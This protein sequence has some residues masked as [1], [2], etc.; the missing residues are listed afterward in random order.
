VH[1]RWSRLLERLDRVALEPAAAIQLRTGALY[2]LGLLECQRDDD[3]AIARLEQLEA[4]GGFDAEAIVNQL[5]FLYHGFRGEI[6]LALRAREK[7]ERYALHQGTAWQVEIWSTSTMSAMYGQT[8]DGAGHKNVLEQLE[9]LKNEIP[10]LTLYWQRAC[11]TQFLVRGDPLRAI[12]AYEQSLLGL[13]PRELIGWAFVRG[14]MAVAHN[15]LG[16]Y[17]EAKRICDETKAVF[18]DD[19]EYV[20]LNLTVY[21]ESAVA[22]AG[23]GNFAAASRS[24]R[25]L[26]DRHAPRKNPM[27][28]G[29]L[30]RARA[31]VARLENDATAFDQHVGM[32]EYWFRSTKNPALIAQCEA[33]RSS[34][35]APGLAP[36][37]PTVMSVAP[38]PTRSNPVAS[39]SDTL[40]ALETALSSCTTQEARR[41]R[42]LRFL[43]EIGRGE[44]AY[45]FTRKGEGC[46]RASHRWG[47]KEPP[48]SLLFQASELL[49]QYVDES[50]ETRSMSVS[51]IEVERSIDVSDGPRFSLLSITKLVGSKVAL[52]GVVAAPA[53]ISPSALPRAVLDR[54]A[55]EFEEV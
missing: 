36:V 25:D 8:R 33:M 3:S 37:P 11:G 30:H 53:S 27:T 52:I 44:Q 48:E 32:M 2:A 34:A 54:L 13:E 55:R 49:S 22:E 24:L 38:A 42:A 28:L 43:A 41:S 6:D 23:I 5:R 40:A 12:L 51:G 46:A 39:G 35:A 16:Q 15:E 1:S 9:R 21:L 29:L 26:F 10:S 18:E 7:V 47:E 19:R 17:A 14:N 4:V 45:F 20:A 50:E 31:R